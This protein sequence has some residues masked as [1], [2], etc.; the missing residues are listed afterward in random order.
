[1]TKQVLRPSTYKK[2]PTP[3]EVCGTFKPMTKSGK[4]CSN[5]CKQKAKNDRNK[6]IG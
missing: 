2:T 6:G 4:Y 3:C 1:M 5:A